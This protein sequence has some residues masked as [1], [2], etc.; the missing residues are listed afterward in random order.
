LIVPTGFAAQLLLLLHVNP[1]D[2]L[3]PISHLGIDQVAS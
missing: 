1:A 3:V 2:D